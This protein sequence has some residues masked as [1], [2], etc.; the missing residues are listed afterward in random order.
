MKI[1]EDKNQLEHY[2]KKYEMDNL[3]QIDIK[4]HMQLISFDEG[5]NI[6]RKGERIEY[7]YFLVEGKIKVY[8][9][10]ENGRVL[11]F[12]F[13]EPLNIIGDAEFFEDDITRCNIQAITETICIAIPLSIIKDKT[14]NDINFIRFLCKKLSEKFLNYTIFSSVNILYPLEN[15][16]ASYILAMSLEIKDSYE[17]IIYIDKLTEIADLLGASYRHLLRTIKKLVDKNI[18]KKEEDSIIILD[19]KRLQELAKEPYKS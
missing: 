19:K 17:T 18:I 16:L 15:R 10:V 3:F 2:I 9:I 4:E 1:L 12:H 7:F 14:Y 5:E 13:Y 11:L 8:T 6:L